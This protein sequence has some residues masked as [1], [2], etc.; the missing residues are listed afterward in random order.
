M[1]RHWGRGS[2]LAVWGVVGLGVAGPAAVPAAGAEDAQAAAAA[3]AASRPEIVVLQALRANPVT[4]PYAIV[5][6]WKGGKVV[7][8]GRVGTKQIHDAAVRI[9][10]A[11]GVSIRDDLTIDTAE[12]HRAAAMAAAAGGALPGSMGASL[13][14]VYPPPLFGRIDDPFFGFEPPLVTYPPWWRALGGREPIRFSAGATTAPG[15]AVVPAGGASNTTLTSIP[16]GPTSRDGSIEMTLDTRGVAVL[17][18]TVPSLADRLAIGQKI[19]QT[20]GVSEVI[21]LLN[22]RSAASET[23]P[24]PP[25]PAAIPAA[26]APAAP[27][28][29]PPEAE[30][31]AERRPAIA[32]DADSV[33]QRLADTF[34]RRPALAH[35]PIKISVRDGI[36][37]LSGKVP[38]VYEAMLAFRAAQQTPGVRAVDDSLEF[39]VPDGE[40]QNPLLQKGRPDD[41]EPYLL[42]QIRRQVG[43]LAHVDQVRLLGDT[44]QVRGVAQREARPRID[45]VLRSMPVLRGFRV[46][47]AFTLE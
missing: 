3:A 17:R 26:R 8:S 25:Q 30:A 38:T 9:A 28:A 42:A 35:L 20:P 22:V 5:T 13:P 31:P 39:V 19:A 40:R 16:L 37:Y 15:G 32:A 21:N 41:V 12:A 4:A 34:A 43:D 7:L 23:P 2:V 10:M 14:Y 44:L 11:T 46:E 27:Q 24:P 47:P 45:A 33:S 6:S 1:L 36:A 29:A 18:G